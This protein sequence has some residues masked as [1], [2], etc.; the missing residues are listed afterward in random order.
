M[1]SNDHDA[2]HSFVFSTPAGFAL[3]RAILAEKLPY[4][5]HYHQLRAVC[6][7]LDDEDVFA[8]TPTGSGKSAILVMY[9][10]VLRAILADP[11]LWPDVKFK[12]GVKRDPMM[13][14]VCPT[15]SLETDMV[16]HRTQWF[17][18]FMLIIC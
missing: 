11:E 5:P 16:R 18:K 14:L 1:I 12:H 6:R 13:I 9:L 3:C 2:R 4:E 10:L 15:K 17:R 7:A 8:V